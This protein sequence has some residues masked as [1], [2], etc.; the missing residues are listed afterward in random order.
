MHIAD[1]SAKPDAISENA[2]VVQLYQMPLSAV[3]TAGL[4][5]MNCY[6]AIGSQTVTRYSLSRLSV[7]SGS[8]AKLMMTKS[9]AC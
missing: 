3:T 5:T 6:T 4:D 9:S 8:L 7:R 2:L 1:S